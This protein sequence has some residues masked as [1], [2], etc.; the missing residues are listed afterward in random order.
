MALVS[1]AARTVATAT[2]VLAELERPAK[3]HEAQDF[4]EADA[5]HVLNR[6]RSL[7][8]EVMSVLVVGHNPTT[9]ILVQSLVDPDDADGADRRDLIARR[10]FPTCALAVCCV[11]VASWRDVER[12]SARLVGFFI[13]PYDRT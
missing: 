9:Q 8:D 12:H 13:P 5:S 7:P 3:V 4:Y 10:G 6:L 2:L 1:P 11:D